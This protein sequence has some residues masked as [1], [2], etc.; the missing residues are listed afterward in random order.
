MGKEVRYCS[1]GRQALSLQIALTNG[2]R[3]EN[4][5]GSLTFQQISTEVVVCGVTDRIAGASSGAGEV[6]K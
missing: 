6:R 1:A 5:L 2:E 3:L 4:S